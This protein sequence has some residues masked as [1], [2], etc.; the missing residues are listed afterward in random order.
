MATVY[1][2]PGVYVEE[3]PKFPPSV[4]Q[5]ETAIPAFIGY[6]DKADD[7][8]PDDLLKKPKRIGSLVEFEQYYGGGSPLKVG[9]VNIDDGGNFKSAKISSS[10]YMYDSLRLFYANGGGDCFIVS[11][12]KY[13]SSVDDTLLNSGIDALMKEDDPTILLFPD[14]VVLDDDK[15]ANVQ[16]HALAH[17]ADDSRMDRMVI[18]DT[19]EADPKGAAFRS[20]VGVNFLSYGA[21]YTPWIKTNL[22]KNVTYADVATV[23][24]RNGASVT[25][26][27]LT[28]DA[29]IQTQITEL[30][31]AYA[32]KKNIVTKTNALPTPSANLR[33]EYNR[34]TALYTPSPDVPKLQAMIKYVFSI[35]FKID[36]FLKAGDVDNCE[37]ELAECNGGCRSTQYLV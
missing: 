14:A 10:Y 26:Q 24:K 11:V 23:I 9:E 7:I 13:G 8:S 32:D 2:T 12:G 27:G 33:D 35:V 28:A 21:A 3:I 19:R 1:K 18:M 15:L 37:H 29:A 20:K 22:P 34:L 25:L 4:A 5:V 30:G 6:T 31:K 36:D 17:C 16:T